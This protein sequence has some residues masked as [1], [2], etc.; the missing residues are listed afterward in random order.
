VP[1]ALLLEKKVVRSFAF[2]VK[3]E[4]RTLRNMAGLILTSAPVIAWRTDKETY[5]AATIHSGV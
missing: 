5:N 4:R 1:L 3:M 2:F